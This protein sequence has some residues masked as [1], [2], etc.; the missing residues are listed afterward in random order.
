MNIFCACALL[1]L[2]K[3]ERESKYSALIPN[4]SGLCVTIWSKGCVAVG[5]TFVVR[6]VE[7]EVL[8]FVRR[9]SAG[10][11]LM[12]SNIVIFVVVQSERLRHEGK[13][14]LKIASS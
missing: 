8:S 5:N 1:E 6:N 7:S 10:H 12:F 2:S 11:G 14:C 3:A 9:S 4:R 13:M